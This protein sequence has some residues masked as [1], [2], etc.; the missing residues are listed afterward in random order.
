MT[1]IS[2]SRSHRQFE[3]Q[4]LIEKCLC[5]HYLLNQWLEF[6]Q[7]N[8]DT[9]IGRGEKVIR[10]CWPWPH[11]QD[12]CIIKW[13]LCAVSWGYRISIAY[14]LFSLEIITANFQRFSH[15]N[16]SLQTLKSHHFPCNTVWNEHK[17]KR[18][19]LLV[20]PASWVLHLHNEK[21]KLVK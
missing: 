11:F 4:I 1:L 15:F 13:A 2:F 9:S 10:F 21:R 6:D 19:I 7:T 18:A 12:H 16:W 17:G 5:A 8:T 20:V 14:Y 3:T